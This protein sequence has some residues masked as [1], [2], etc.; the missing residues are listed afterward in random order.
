MDANYKVQGEFRLWL[1]DSTRRQEIELAH[2]EM[3]FE[4]KLALVAEEDTGWVKNVVTDYG[5][6]RLIVNSWGS[7]SFN[8][9]ISTV[10]SPGN[11]RRTSVNFPY[12]TGP[13]ITIPS[14]VD[15]DRPT[16]LQTRTGTF[17]SVGVSRT[18]NIVG[19]TTFSAIS[20]DGFLNGVVAYSK[21]PSTKTQGAAQTADVQYRVTW[22]LD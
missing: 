11:V 7:T 5:R 4:Q 17:A 1:S 2:P 14:I 15:L 13:Q 6:R 8:L 18:I 19:L 21:L 9:F 16:L 12:T 20:S 22:S 3:P 10:T